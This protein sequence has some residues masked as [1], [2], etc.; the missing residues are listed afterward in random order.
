MNVDMIC[1]VVVLTVRGSE[2]MEKIELPKKCGDLILS[3]FK[4]YKTGE[5]ITESIEDSMQTV[6]RWIKTPISEEDERIIKGSEEHELK[7]WTEYFEDVVMGVKPFEIRKNDRDFKVGDIL[8]LKEY[9][10]E[11]NNYTGRS[12]KKKISCIFNGGQFGIKKDYVIL[13]LC[14]D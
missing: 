7:I 13:G 10:S 9:N 4:R 11:T 6:E 5:S 12:I 2:S 14:Y 3:I 8:H 1:Q